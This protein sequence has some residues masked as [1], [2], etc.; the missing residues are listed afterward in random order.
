VS[1][2]RTCTVGDGLISSVVWCGNEQLI[3]KGLR[4][5]PLIGDLYTIDGVVWMVVRDAERYELEPVP[6][7][8][9]S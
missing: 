8:E 2:I 4:R 9:P 6:D 7:E 3:L 1:R 5:S